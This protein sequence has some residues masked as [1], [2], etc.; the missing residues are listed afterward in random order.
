M[1]KFDVTTLSETK[2]TRTV[3]QILREDIQKLRAIIK[4]LADELDEFGVDVLG[5]VNAVVSRTA[6][7]PSGG[8]FTLLLQ[9]IYF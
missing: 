9:K 1:V 5:D 3:I 6:S 8:E 2:V 7:S 4:E